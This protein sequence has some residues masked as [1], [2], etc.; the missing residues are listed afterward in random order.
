MLPYI[1][2]FLQTP[3]MPIIRSPAHIPLILYIHICVHIHI[4][5]LLSLISVVCVYMTAPR[6]GG[7]EGLLYV[8]KRKSKASGR[9]I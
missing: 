2:F 1:L 9:H 4:H 3:L 8:D 5:I 7:E 6:Y